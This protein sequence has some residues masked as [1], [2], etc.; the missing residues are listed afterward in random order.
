MS[1]IDRKLV[2]AIKESNSIDITFVLG[3]E[4]VVIP[5]RGDKLLAHDVAIALQ[6]FINR[7]S[8]PQKI[9]K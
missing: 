4:K 8:R 5:I 1:P 2:E 7:K 6:G 3:Y 9:E